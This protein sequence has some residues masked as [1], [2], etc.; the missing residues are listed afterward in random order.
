[1][2]VNDKLGPDYK[3][4]GFAADPD[5]KTSVFDPYKDDMMI[6]LKNGSQNLRSSHQAPHGMPRQ[7]A[8]LGQQ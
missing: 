5:I 7:Q 1:M 4:N 8:L 6:N 3:P 2:M